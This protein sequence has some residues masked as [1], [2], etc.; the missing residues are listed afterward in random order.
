LQEAEVDLQTLASDEEE[1]D[2][3]EQRLA[4]QLPPLAA[5]LHSSIVYAELE[6]PLEQQLHL[7]HDEDDEDEEHEEHLLQEELELFL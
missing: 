5:R 2:E 4:C 6:Q 3:Q 1:E 7:E